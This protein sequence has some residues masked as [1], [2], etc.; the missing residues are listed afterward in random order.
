MEYLEH[1]NLNNECFI[2]HEQKNMMDKIAGL[3]RNHG[4]SVEP[5]FI[6]TDTNHVS[7]PVLSSY[8]TL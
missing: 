4:N 2:I 8:G 5:L 6:E 7:V 3:I 1:P